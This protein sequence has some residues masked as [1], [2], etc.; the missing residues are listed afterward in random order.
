MPP[1]VEL[2]SGRIGAQQRDFPKKADDKNAQAKD[3]PEKDEAEKEG[4]DNDQAEN[5]KEAPDNNPLKKTNKPQRKRKKSDGPIAVD[6]ESEDE[7]DKNGRFKPKEVSRI[8]AEYDI[9]S[10]QPLSQ[11]MMLSRDGIDVDTTASARLL[12]MHTI[13]QAAEQKNM[14]TILK[15]AEQKMESRVFKNFKY[16]LLNSYDDKSYQ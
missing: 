2:T 10:I 13:L 7:K 5:E 16:A 14:H 4:P 3:A 6:S 8:L 11:Q 1:A 12:N 9:A 15:A